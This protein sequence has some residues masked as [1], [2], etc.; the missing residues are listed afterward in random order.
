M[1]T[2]TFITPVI[3]T[4]QISCQSAERFQPSQV[5][6]STPAHISTNTSEEPSMEHD[7]FHKAN[8]LN[9]IKRHLTL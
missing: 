3:P 1:T 8:A 9:I 6:V 4:T 7:T 5:N 2:H